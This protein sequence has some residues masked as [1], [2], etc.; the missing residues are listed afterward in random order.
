MIELIGVVNVDADGGLEE[1]SV[2]V[3]LA[4]DM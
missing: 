4:T 3:R 1:G 2:G